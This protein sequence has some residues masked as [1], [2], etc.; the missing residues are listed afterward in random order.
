ISNGAPEDQFRVAIWAVPWKTEALYVSPEDTGFDLRASIG[1]PAVAG[2]LLQPLAPGF[3]GR[4]LPSGAIDVLLSDGELQNIS[5]LQLLNGANAA[6]IRSS[7]G[8]WELV[9]F[10]DAEETAPS[11]WRLSGLL[12]GQ[13]G[14][15][16]AMAAGAAV[17]ASFV[18]LDEA[19]KPAGLLSS[20]IGLS[21]NWR[22]GPSGEDFS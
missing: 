6:A 5:K 21:L 10:L 15:E 11:V 7:N 9:Q 4:V 13:L 17:G 19:V 1:V 12:R 14:T 18:L 2:E 3:A 20:E 8:A 16:D 22:V